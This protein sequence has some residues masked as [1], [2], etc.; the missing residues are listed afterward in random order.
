MEL[1]KHIRSFGAPPVA[2][3]Q[4]GASILNAEMDRF[5]TRTPRSRAEWE[6]ARQVLPSGVCS[7]FRVMEPHPLFAASAKGSRLQDVDG[8]DYVDWSLAQTTLLAGHAHPIVLEAARRQT[9]KG[10]LTCQPS[11]LTADLAEVVRDR[12]RLEMVRFVNTGA[13]AAFYTTRVAR[14]ATGRDLIMKFEICYHGSSA[15]L[16]VGKVAP[17]LPPGSPVWLGYAE[18]TTGVPA[19][20]F[21]KT[22]VADYNELDSVRAL[23]REH[24]GAIAG[25]LLEP[26][27]LNMG[28]IPPREGFL[29]GLREICD[30]EG[31]MLIFDEVKVGCKLGPMGAGEY[32]GVAPDLVAMAKSIG[33]GFPIGLFGGRREVM[34][35][36]E[37]GGVTHVGTY[38]ANPVNLA[39]AHA[40]LTR[41]FT[42]ESYDRVF[43]L[44]RL[45]AEGFREII[46]RIGLDAHVVTI[47]ANGCLF[48][49]R[50]PVANLRDFL[51]ARHASD[52]IFS[53]GM[54]NRGVLMGLGPEDPWTVSVQ[55]TE[56]DVEETLRAFRDLAP[57]LA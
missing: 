6:R 8:H 33:G 36:I 12:F 7:S 17:D 4:A 11:P 18:W 2:S 48:L 40:T 19:T 3:P 20:F 23:F 26:V 50:H 35:T 42:P 44:N 31:A 15:D 21:E 49:T 41:V 25:V 10:A 29:E 34:H 9:E 51:R 1:D 38:T 39:A 28:V 47:G 56:V 43:S 24:P 57:L 46:D 37:E 52:G 13:E 30:R 45:L 5:R 54:M 53:L 16:M 32:F 55:H 27:A 14:A 22:V